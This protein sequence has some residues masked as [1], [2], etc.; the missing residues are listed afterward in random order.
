MCVSL[1]SRAAMASVM[2]H[3]PIVHTKSSRFLR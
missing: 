1:P 2:P 3:S